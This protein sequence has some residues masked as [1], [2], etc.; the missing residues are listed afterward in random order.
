MNAAI[1]SYSCLRLLVAALTGAAGLIYQTQAAEQPNDS[2]R[3]VQAPKPAEKE[4][5]GR[6]IR[7]LFGHQDRVNSVG[8][9]PDGRWIA[10]AASDGTARWSAVPR[11]GNLC[12]R[13]AS[14]IKNSPVVVLL[15]IDSPPL[16]G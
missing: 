5:M 6:P 10:T 15:M 9:S 8:Y 1:F 7:S 4:A 13:S 12:I 3:V 11:I 14:A 16:P 2:N